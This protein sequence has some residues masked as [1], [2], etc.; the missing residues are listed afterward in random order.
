MLKHFQM[1]AAYNLWANTLVYAAAAEL[2]DAEYRENKGA[3]FGS[4]HG[5]LNHILAA[6][7]IWMKRFTG[8]GDA[9]V[10][11]D[12]VLFDDLKS[13][14]A[15]RQKED[16]RIIGW[17]DSLSEEAL[18]QSFTYTPVSNPVEITQ[19]LSPALTHVFNHHTHHRGQAH[20]I[21][22]SLGKPSQALDMS[23]FLRTEMGMR[24]L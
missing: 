5:T 22:T 12:A 9:P 10:T 15:A 19:P 8:G 16:A 7:R 11:L 21:L 2:S 3:F 23:Y 13:L 6:D 20:M 17:I 14:T 18:S 1:F 4:M 24:F